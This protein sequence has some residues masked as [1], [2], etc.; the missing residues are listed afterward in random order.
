MATLAP[1]S[2]ADP[3]TAHNGADMWLIQVYN[4]ILYPVGFGFVYP[5]LLI[6]KFANRA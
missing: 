5:G 6:H 3:A 1:N 4:P 2:T